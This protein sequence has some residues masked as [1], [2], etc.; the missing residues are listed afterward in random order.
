[1]KLVVKMLQACV[2]HSFFRRGLWFSPAGALNICVAMEIKSSLSFL[3]LPLTT[4]FTHTHTSSPFDSTLFPKPAADILFSGA[5]PVRLA[6]HKRDLNITIETQHTNIEVV[7]NY[8]SRKIWMRY[9]HYKLLSWWQ[10]FISLST[11][12]LSEDELN[13]RKKP[14]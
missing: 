6:N 14:C 4:K 7:Y 12:P 9:C 3:L 10:R 11:V 2:L 13:K 5:Y 8:W 1:M